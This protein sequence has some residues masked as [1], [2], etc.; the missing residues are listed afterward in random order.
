MEPYFINWANFIFTDSVTFNAIKSKEEITKKKLSITL[1]IAEKQLETRIL[2]QLFLKN[3]DLKC[4]GKQ[5]A[6][7]A[8]IQVR[9][10]AMN[11]ESAVTLYGIIDSYTTIAGARTDWG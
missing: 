7:L 1:R 8:K 9:R 10:A 3:R 6:V 4:M 2:C 11:L 5:C